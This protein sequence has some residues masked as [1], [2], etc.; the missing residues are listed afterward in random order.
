MDVGEAVDL[1]KEYLA[2]E[3]GRQARAAVAA[4]MIAAAPLVMRIPAVRAH[5]LGRLLAL[6]GGAAAVVKAAEL[7][8]DWEPAL[9]RTGE[10]P[11]R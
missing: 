5:P 6:V 7:L 10:A 1:A 9:A 11:A 8:R 3:R 2:S 4:G